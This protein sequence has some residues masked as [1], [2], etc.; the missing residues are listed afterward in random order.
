MGRDTLSYPDADRI[1]AEL[2][3]NSEGLTR[4]EISGLFGRNR[5]QEEIGSA[6]ARLEER[7][8]AVRT[9]RPTSGR[10]EE[11]WIAGGGG[12]KETK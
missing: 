4:T 2:R 12:T 5:T 11:L 9:M 7:G 6:L 8:P 10:P 3:A 1:L